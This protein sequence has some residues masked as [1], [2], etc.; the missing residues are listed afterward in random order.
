MVQ[1][2]V[3]VILIAAVLPRDYSIFTEGAY[4]GLSSHVRRRIERAMI[5]GLVSGIRLAF[6]HRSEQIERASQTPSI[7]PATETVLSDLPSTI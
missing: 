5:V 1:E 2:T 4:E 3:L 7:P 6:S